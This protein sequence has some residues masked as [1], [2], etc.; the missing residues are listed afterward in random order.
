MHQADE[1]AWKVPMF[2]KPELGTL[3]PFTVASQE[4]M[5]GQLSQV[6]LH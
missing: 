5:G 3:A 1:I 6:R 4:T 2:P